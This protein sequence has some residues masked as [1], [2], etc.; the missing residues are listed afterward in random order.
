MANTEQK[1]TDTSRND[2]YTGHGEKYTRKKEQAIT[3]LM[4]SSTVE[5]AA[6][7]VGVDRSTLYR[8][9]DRDEFQRQ[10]RE[11][12]RSALNQAI[13][14]LQQVS[15]DAVTTLQDVMNDPEARDGDRIRAA[16]KVLKFAVD[17]AE[18][19]DLQERLSELE[20]V[21]IERGEDNER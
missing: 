18:I 10:Y 2:K 19:E 6:D 16:E 8:W 12:R 14:R 11:A 15:R 20:S 17:T 1:P 3:A 21:L 4:T 5:D 9:L 13:A 7:H